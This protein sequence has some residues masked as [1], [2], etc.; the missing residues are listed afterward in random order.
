[1]SGTLPVVQQWAA[2]VRYFEANAVLTGGPDCPDNLPIQDLADRTEYLKAQLEAKTGQ[3]TEAESGIASLASQAEALAGTDDA[4][5]MTA[6]KVKAVI[7]A[8]VAAAPGTL[9]TLNELAAALGDD[10][11]FA[12]TMANA[13]AG[14]EDKTALKGGAYTDKT[15]Y[16]YD[17]TQDRLMKTGDFGKGTKSMSVTSTDANLIDV[18]ATYFMSNLAANIPV[19]EYGWLEYSPNDVG[20]SARQV[21]QTVSNRLFHRAAT[22]GVWSS[23]TEVFN[24]LNSPAL[25][26]VNGWQKL[27]GGFILQAGSYSVSTTNETYNL[28]FPTTFPNAVIGVFP[29]QYTSNTTV[30][31]EANAVVFNQTTSGCS[32]NMRNG[33]APEDVKWFAIGY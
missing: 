24:T 13:L 6:L 4:K 18:S 30:S 11:N 22:S 20:G 21:Y 2:G 9:D 33:Y 19:A 3:A 10:P 8:L 29:I 5:I 31:S 25:L 7:D 15:A 12:T 28:T 26:S 27:L 1:M 32:I 16:N 17:S 14:K 23:W